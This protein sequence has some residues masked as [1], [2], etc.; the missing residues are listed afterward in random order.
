[1]AVAA[2]DER[3]A[4]LASAC[5]ALGSPTRLKMLALLCER[6]R[7]CGDMVKLFS[8]S[9]STVSHHLKA[10]KEAGLVLSEEHGAATCYRVNQPRLVELG[11][12]L[13]R[14]FS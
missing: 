10:L 11:H 14:L 9:Q 12:E 2:G 8:L 1:M 5:R 4:E 13:Q 3:L 6:E 7:Y